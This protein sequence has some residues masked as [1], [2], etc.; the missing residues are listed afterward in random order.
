MNNYGYHFGKEMC[1]T[2]SVAEV[3]LKVASNYI[4]WALIQVYNNQ[5]N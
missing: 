3:E 1:V 5:F 2:H 4:L